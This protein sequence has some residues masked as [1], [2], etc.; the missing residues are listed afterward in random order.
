WKVVEQLHAVLKILKDFTLLFS[1][2]MPNLA[3]VI[4]AMDHTDKHITTYAC[5]K[6][7]LQSICSAMSLTKGSPNYCY[8][9]TDSSEVY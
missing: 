3:T 1:H 2:S 6:S 7:Y 8:S 4:P 5:D 9:V